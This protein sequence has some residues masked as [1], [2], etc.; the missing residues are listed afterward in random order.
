MLFAWSFSF[1]QEQPKSS[2]EMATLNGTVT[3]QTGAVVTGAKVLLT[4]E[5]GEKF[6]TQSNDNGAYS[7]AG[8]KPGTYT[9]TV[10]ALNFAAKTFD[11][12]ALTASHE[13]TLDAA[14]QP[15][16]EKTE[17][18]VQSGG[19]GQVETETASVSGTISEKQ[20]VSI[21][22]NGRNFTQ[23]IALAPGVSNQT[24]QDEAKV[25]VVGS[26][27]YSVNGGRVEYNTFE[28][29]GS[30]VL[31]TG[32]NGASS[33]L[34][35]FPSLDAIQE[36]KVLT[37]N[38]GAQFGRTASGTVQVTTKSG[39]AKLH[40]NLYEFIRN[41]AFNAR[42]YFDVVY[43][44]PPPLGQTCC[45]ETFGTKAPLYR[46]QDFGGTIGGPLF[47]PHVFNEKK[48]KTFFF[49]SEEARLE[50]TPTE[51]NQAVPGLKERGLILTTQGIQQNLQISPVTGAVYQD[52]DFTDVCAPGGAPFVRA[53]YPDCP[54]VTSAGNGLLEAA[55]HLEVPAV[56]GVP[57]L[58]VDKNAM[59]ILN[60]NLIPLPNAPYGCN[61]SLPN[62]NSFQNNYDPTDP[63]HCY[64]ASVSPSTYWRE[65][66][67]RIDQIITNNLKVSFRYIHDAWNTTVLTPQWGAVRNTFP[68]VQNDFVGPGLSL[69][70]HVTDTIS[71]TLLNDLVLS[72]VNSGITLSDQNGPGGAQFQRNPVLDQPLVPDPSAP[73]VCNPTL[74]VDPAT[75]IPECAMGYIFNNGFGGKMPGVNF[76]GT[77]AAYGGE[78]FAV[79]P[80]YMPWGHTSPTYSLRDDI[81]K[82]IGK[83]TLQFGAQYVYFQRNQTNNAIGAAS[84]D[85]QGLLTFSNLVHSSGNAFADFLLQNPLSNGS[86]LV[87]GFI[88]SFTQDST[89][90]R[91]YQRYQL[92][93]P[94]FQDDWKVT[95]RLTLNLGLRVSLF[96]TYHEKYHNAWNWEASRFNSTRFSVDPVYGELLDNN[97]GS[98]P[99]SFNPVT[100]QLDPGVVSDLGLVQCGV[101]GVPAG[102]MSGHLF[103]P[104]PRVGFAWD[105][106]GDGKTSVRGG[107]G[108]FFEHGTGNEANTGSLEASAP[109]V[110]SMTQPLPANYSCIGNVGYGNATNP[111]C[112]TSLGYFLGI[113]PPPAGSAFPLDV[114]SIPTK[115]VWPYAQQWSFGV[116]RQVS[117]NDVIN[118]AYVGSK[119]TH[120]TI[121]RQLNQLHPIPASENPFGPNE[122]LTIADCTVPSTGAAIHIA[123]GDGFTP[124]LL[125][126]GTL[127]TP[128]NPAYVN[129]QAAC[130]N[131][132]IPNVNSLPGHPYPG[133]GRVLSLQNVANSSYNALQWTLQHTSGPLAAGLSY[134]YSHS[135][136]NA[137]DRS[138]PVLANSYDLT[139]N[140]ASSSFDQR[141]LLN[142]N[143]IYR[144]PF[145]RL[146]RTFADWLGGVPGAATDLE[147]EE[148]P[149]NEPR[150]PIP[151]PPTPSRLMRAIFDGWELSGVTLFQS[152]NPF[153]IINSAGNT[154]IS[155]T[156]NAGVA[157][158]LGNVTQGFAASYPDV[159]RG[160][161]SPG[162]NPASFGPLIG[163]PSQFVAPRGLTFGDAGRNY[164]NNPGRLNFDTAV[165]KHFKL[166]ET[167]DLEFRAEAFN[168]FNHTQFR[169]YDPDNP[170]S[171]GNNVISCYAGPFYSAGFAGSG[172]NCVTGASF[173]HPLDAHRPRTLQFGLKL[174]F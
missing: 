163:N 154:G 142:I 55:T 80:S 168:V 57:F 120:L 73:G 94:Y 146:G 16:G 162:N 29:D 22:L 108:I 165:L 89:Q 1:A 158:G 38:Y 36:M 92:G 96:G 23:L 155:L 20:V 68:T 30:D 115:A 149:G 35:V 164:F 58:G 76:Q 172:G 32:L 39:T 173:L 153:T 28:V 152:G 140:R 104:A 10:T 6:E 79:D 143:Y 12:V 51:Y 112:T 103:N 90:G 156:D 50:K 166:S 111:E 81:G 97:A 95:P 116:Q 14:L 102:C 124:F 74:S 66:L 93:E 107:Y 49:F 113:A 53:Q 5:A 171:I 44:T 72:Y 24:G 105:P 4:N 77:N 60:S 56:F 63:N 125:Q 147:V 41:E 69:V 151:P 99:V 31:N 9:M 136:D 139:A 159:I 34:M 13:L 106:W 65:E 134:S 127:V 137:S 161:P 61:F 45:S 160:L 3:D 37:S 132:N 167:S 8:I 47:I 67:F 118:I 129:L 128:Q 7:F 54:S 133:L 11:L 83:H 71:P 17:V 75:L 59:A 88:Q 135:I 19:A 169:I 33:T 62:L 27:K 15:A 86:G 109:R 141:H 119:G 148:S 46:R 101:N 98:T 100:F 78:G 131:P 52:F 48:D 110:L 82:S 18:N 26:V 126:D 42:N 170:G 87:E 150:K 91:Y 40:G 122:P 174:G 64:D 145:L 114:T 123:P 144:L 43:T 25:G 130:T 70:A 84:G 85:M 21:G 138:D 121:E 157:E 117:K 2:T